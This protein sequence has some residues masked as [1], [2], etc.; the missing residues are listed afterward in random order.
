M[1]KIRKKSLFNVS[2]NNIS[3]TMK[4][5]E[6]ESGAITELFYIFFY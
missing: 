2:T 6:V 4:S 3:Y 5:L 1:R